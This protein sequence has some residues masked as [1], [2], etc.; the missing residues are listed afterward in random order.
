MNK[1]IKISL[2]FFLISLIFFWFLDYDFK[3]KQFTFKNIKSFLSKQTITSLKDIYTNFIDV[4]FIKTE[5]NT[6]LLNNQKIIYE[7]YSNKL[8]KNR[9]YLEQNSKNIFL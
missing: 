8:I 3:K 2:I 6:F 4:Y 7:K 9:Y 1:L 5:E